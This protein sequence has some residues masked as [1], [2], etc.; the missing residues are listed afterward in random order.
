ML[1]MRI[2]DRKT[3]LDY[4]D[5]IFYAVCFVV[6]LVNDDQFHIKLDQSF[7]G[8]LKVMVTHSDSYIRCASTIVFSSQK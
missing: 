2:C 8:I 4:G 1:N 6:V 5:I 7:G 3:N